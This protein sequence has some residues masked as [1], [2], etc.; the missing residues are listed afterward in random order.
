MITSSFKSCRRGL[1]LQNPLLLLQL[2]PS[3]RTFSQLPDRSIITTTT[4]RSLNMADSNSQQ[5]WSAANVRSTFIDYFVKKRAH[6]FGMF[7]F[8]LLFRRKQ[9]SSS[10]RANEHSFSL[11]TTV[12]SS[13]VVPHSDPTLLFANA[14][15]NQYKSIFLGTVD[16]SSDFASLKRAT[17]SQKASQDFFFLINIYKYATVLTCSSQCIRAGGKHNVLFESD[18]FSCSH[19][20]VV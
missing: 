3:T 16:P 2:S 15:M 4:T 7:P 9:S 5:Q 8:F 18:H 11:P 14:G 20:H 1:L 17:N 12:P 13:S 10:S 6:T 19:R